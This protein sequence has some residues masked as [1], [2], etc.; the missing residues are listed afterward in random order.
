M[1]IPNKIVL[2]FAIALT[3]AS[4][5]AAQR[6]KEPAKPADT[7]VDV[8][9]TLQVAGQPYHSVGKA[10]CLHAPV[11][12][13][14]STVA[15]MWSVQ[16]TDGQRSITLTLWRPKSKSGDMFSLSV[17]TGNKPYL[18]NTVALG[19]K[20]AVQGSGKVTLTTLGAAG[21]FTINAS[22][23]NGAAITGTIKCSAFTAAIAEGGN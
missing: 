21:T 20:S 13:I 7:K 9:I 10:A 2:S 19:G 22:E 1:R 8:A 23:A 3:I 17:A 6:R 15:E 14:Y 5:A 4:A 11:A 16:Q 12:S 18:V